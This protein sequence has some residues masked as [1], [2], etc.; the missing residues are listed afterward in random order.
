MLNGVGGAAQNDR[1]GTAGLWAPLT[2]PVSYMSSIP[3]DPFFG[4]EQDKG[5]NLIAQDIIPPFAY[6]YADEDPA[7]PGSDIGLAFFAP[8]NRL[9]ESAGVKPI[10]EGNY[11]A[12]GAG[13]DGSR[14][15][16]NTDMGF[17]L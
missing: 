10:R 7:I 9:A 4:F 17:L 14:G 3:I 13:P 15:G 11:V 6:M 16:Y 12:I 1:G 5:S 2:S 8:G